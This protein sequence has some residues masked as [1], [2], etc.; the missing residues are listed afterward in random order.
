MHKKIVHSFINKLK[1]IEDGKLIIDTTCKEEHIV[2][3]EIKCT[4][5]KFLDSR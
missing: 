5:S 4:I 2:D 1:S 3:L